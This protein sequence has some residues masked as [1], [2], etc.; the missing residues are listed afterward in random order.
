LKTKHLLSVLALWMFG[1]L[2]A[3]RAADEAI[4]LDTPTGKLAGSLLLPARTGRMPV[5]LII[6]GSGPTD[7]DGN[8]NLMKGPN[9][10]LKMLA[11]A[12]ADAGYASVRYDKRGIGAS[13]AAMWSEAD[14]RFDTYVDDAAAW[15]DKLAHDPRFS[16]VVVIGHSEGSLI[17]M[18]AAR[19]AKAGGFISLAGAG[20]AAYELLRQ[21]LAGKLPGELAVANERILTALQH[22]EKSEPVPPALAGF[23]RPSVQP[24]L[25]SWFKYVPAE[26]IALLEVP[27][28]IVQGDTDIQVDGKEAA[29]LKAAKPQ[30]QLALVPGMNHV[31]KMVPADMARQAASYGDP[32]LPLAPALRSAIL[33]FMG[34]L[35]AR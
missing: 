32:T 10:S 20:H 25:I 17:G 30:A 5:A 28:L 7:R 15:I 13:A 18:V 2:C 1:A 21:Q 4:V 16:S 24:Y 31:L 26:R 14:L 3:A 19:K 23:Y 11:Q 29:A 34:K 22:G 8:N 9:D 33:D 6:A 27:V 35:D 12:L